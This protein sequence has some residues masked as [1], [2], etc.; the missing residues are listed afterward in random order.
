MASRPPRADVIAAILNDMTS[1]LRS[2]LKRSLGAVILMLVGVTVASGALLV[3][4][5][6]ART[7]LSDMSTRLPGEI[8]SLWYMR[9]TVTATADPAS[10]H[11]E[12]PSFSALQLSQAVQ[13][14]L[15]L[16]CFFEITSRPVLVRG[17][18][19]RVTLYVYD[20]KVPL[21]GGTATA[22]LERAWQDRGVVVNMALAGKFPDFRP[23]E[24]I[25][26]GPGGAHPV[27]EVIGPSSRVSPI[28]SV[29]VPAILAPPA[30]RSTAVAMYL[31]AGRSSVEVADHFVAQFRETCPGA[32]VTTASGVETLGPDIHEARTVAALAVS[33]GL[34]IAFVAFV[35]VG[36]LG[37]L[38]VLNRTRSLA[39]RRALGAT[40][41]LVRLY[42]VFDLVSV[43]LIALVIG[44]ALGSVALRTWALDVSAIDLA[45]PVII[46]VSASVV[47]GVVLNR[48]VNR[49]DPGELM[50]RS[51]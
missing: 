9:S 26:L 21:H 35:N 32:T 7:T 5:A 16:G 38:W 12:V 47:I 41:A 23:G 45:P 48:V 49:P 37:S 46:T 14:G 27:V 25:D 39:V 15:V 10:G 31:P 20:G 1:G 4:F 6:L 44:L 19:L 8:E 51:L 33:G 50:G 17:Q 28:P 22:S 11:I 40:S 30:A 36:T 18:E 3:A 13:S 2:Q 42:I 29:F 43:A 24:L 34:L